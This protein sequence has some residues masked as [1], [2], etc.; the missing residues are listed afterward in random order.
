MVDIISSLFDEVNKFVAKQTCQTDTPILEPDSIRH[1]AEFIQ[2]TAMGGTQDDRII[3]FAFSAK[4]YIAVKEHDLL[5][6]NSMP[7]R[8]WTEFMRD[9]DGHSVQAFAVEI[10]TANGTGEDMLVEGE[11]YDL[12]LQEVESILDSDTILL[13][14]EYEV[15]GSPDKR[16]TCNDPTALAIMQ[17]DLHIARTSQK[18][19]IPEDC[20]FC[21]RDINGKCQLFK[22]K[23]ESVNLKVRIGFADSQ[24]GVQLINGTQ[25]E[26]QTFPIRFCPMCGRKL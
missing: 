19:N 7:F 20:A 10:M 25:T 21:H 8:Q 22:I 15:A 11:I 1:W 4:G 23:M 16:F 18:Q 12:N 3:Y 24:M 13:K 2:R 6:I 14:S 26:K 9:S 5:I 17:H